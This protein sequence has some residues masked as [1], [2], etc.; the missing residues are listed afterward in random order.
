MQVT[1][2]VY[3][4]Q[5]SLTVLTQGTACLPPLV[6]PYRSP[7]PFLTVLICRAA[8]EEI[9]RST[10]LGLNVQISQSQNKSLPLRDCDDLFTHSVIGVSSWII[11]RCHCATVLRSHYMPTAITW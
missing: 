11:L 10:G 7:H 9:V 4:N 8:E 5:G 6:H 3:T 1:L 2:R